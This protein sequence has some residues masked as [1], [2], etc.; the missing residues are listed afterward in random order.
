M[1]RRRID[2]GWHVPAE[3]FD[4]DAQDRERGRVRMLNGALEGG[5]EDWT[6]SLAQYEPVSELILE[7]LETMQTTTGP[8]CFG[9]W[10]T[11]FRIVSAPT[12]HS[13]ADD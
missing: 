8:C 13:P 3:A 5:M 10:S 7:I 4:Q 12:R 2:G 1:A 6:M 9:N 11:S